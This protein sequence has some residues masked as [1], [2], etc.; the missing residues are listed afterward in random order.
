M[1]PLTVL[2]DPV[3]RSLLD[4]LAAGECPAGQ[5]ASA[6]RADF[7]IGASA[8]SQHLAVLRQAGFVAMRPR[9]RERLYRISGEGFSV[10]QGWLD[11]FRPFW[12]A[13]FDR[14]AADL[15]REAGDGNSRIS[16]S[17]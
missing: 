6:A 12:S 7:G 9:G 17:P 5:L 3:R 15:D 13:A 14:L 8:V 16:E 11:R 4:R 10:A 2:G 1:H